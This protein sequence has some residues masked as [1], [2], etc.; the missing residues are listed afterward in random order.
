M[1]CKE[2]IAVCSEI[3]TKHTNVLCGQ[4]VELTFSPRE[5]RRILHPDVGTKE[6]R[7]TALTVGPKHHI[8]QNPDVI[9]HRP[10][11]ILAHSMNIVVSHCRLF[12]YTRFIR[13]CIS[14]YSS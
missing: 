8:S 14:Q 12:I 5:I 4:N 6:I 11:D 1:L 10:S 13:Y 7:P 2:I 9:N 3:H